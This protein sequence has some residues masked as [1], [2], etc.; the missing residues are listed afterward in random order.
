MD[1]KKRYIIEITYT[2]DK[3]LEVESLDITTDDLEWSMEQYKRNRPPLEW[4]V[5]HEYGSGL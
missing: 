1:K 3:G 4:R 5:V 2:D